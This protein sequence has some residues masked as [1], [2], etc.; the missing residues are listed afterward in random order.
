M[1]YAIFSLLLIATMAG[2][3]AGDGD[4]ARVGQKCPEVAG[5]TSDG[6]RLSAE[7]LKGKV[8]LLDFFAT[9]CGPC[10][11]EMPH[12][13]RDVWQKYQGDGLVVVAVGREH[14]VEEL[15]KFKDSKQFSFT[16]LADPK[17]EIYSRFA[18]EYIPRCYVVGKDGII[19]YAAMGWQPAEF[20]KMKGGI[21]AELKR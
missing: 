17:R 9:W 5:V 21:A 1:R 6:N 13:E 2:A 15:K 4:V 10:M 12:V 8:V 7:S 19:K 11:Q 3:R 18:T 16:L 14:T 20:E